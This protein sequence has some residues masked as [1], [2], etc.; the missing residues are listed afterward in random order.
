MHA[1]TWAYRG[2]FIWT[3][4]VCRMRSFIPWFLWYTCTYH[5]LEHHC[6]TQLS[7]S[8]PLA[9]LLC[10]VP[11]AWSELPVRVP[12]SEKQYPY[13]SAS[14]CWAVQMES[15]G[16]TIRPSPKPPAQWNSFSAAA[17]KR[18]WFQEVNGG[19]RYLGSNFRVLQGLRVEWKEM[20]LPGGSLFPRTPGSCW[21]NG[22]HETPRRW[23]D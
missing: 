16:I 22:E 11:V 3:A 12:G 10:L 5:L 19:G 21:M 9:P 14:Q 17:E 13:C 7:F 8:I 4:S 1:N 20:A 23:R 15:E 18:V 6:S 2:I